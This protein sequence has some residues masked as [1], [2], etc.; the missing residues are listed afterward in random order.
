VGTAGCAWWVVCWCGRW[1]HD[2]VVEQ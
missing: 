2:E 1:G